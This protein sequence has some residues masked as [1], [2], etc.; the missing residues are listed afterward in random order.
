MTLHYRTRG[1][2]YPLVHMLTH[3]STQLSSDFSNTLMAHVYTV[4]PT[5]IPSLPTPKEDCSEEELMESLGMLK[6]KNGEY[7]TFDR[8]LAR[9]E[10]RTCFTTTL[11]VV[12]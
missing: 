2:G 1:D 11:C 4:C 12:N 6:G 7:E 10:V 8:F 9:T 5:A 3:A